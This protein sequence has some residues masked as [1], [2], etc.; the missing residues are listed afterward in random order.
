MNRVAL[1]LVVILSACAS[2]REHLYTL[3][4]VEPTVTATALEVQPTVIVG[5]VTLPLEVDRPQLL[6]R[7][8]PYHVTLAEQERWAVP[9]RDAL[10]RLLA[11]ELSRRVPGQH[12]VPAANGAV[13]T[14]TGRLAV[15]VLLFEGSRAA[16][17]A[18]RV[19]WVYRSFTRESAP[20]E[21][22]AEAHAGSSDRSYEGFV[23][24]LSRASR[25]VADR[26]AS[27][28]PVDR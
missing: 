24:A 14:A 5:P 26:I 28:L 3:Q 8:G 11:D 7:V 27:Q 2:P 17:A 6:E 10:P 19:H 21:G 20:L 25:E 9:L 15:D 23:E 4:D 12:F 22:D 18:V 13:A 16:G 1:V